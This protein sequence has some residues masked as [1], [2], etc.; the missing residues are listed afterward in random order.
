MTPSYF[1]DE[2]NIDDVR[3]RINPSN[4]NLFAFDYFSE[5]DNDIKETDLIRL[6]NM[7]ECDY[8]GSRK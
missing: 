2:A 7:K 4:Y 1:D 6:K 3:Q 5:M 8:Y